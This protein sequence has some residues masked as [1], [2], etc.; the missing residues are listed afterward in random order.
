MSIMKFAGAAVALLLAAGC[1]VTVNNESVADQADVLGE[2]L[3]N[4]AESAGN[5]IDSAADA[6]EN[7]VGDIDINVDTDGNDGAEMEAAET[8]NAAA[9]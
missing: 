6:V 3:E 7:R 8:G 9:N 5:R 4:A 1:D 2:R